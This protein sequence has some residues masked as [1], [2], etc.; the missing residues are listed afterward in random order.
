MY[1]HPDDKTNWMLFVRANSTAMTELVTFYVIVL[2][3]SCRYQ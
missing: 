3:R 1:A 2:Q